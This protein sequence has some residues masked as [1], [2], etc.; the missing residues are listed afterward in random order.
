LIHPAIWRRRRHATIAATR[1][2]SK[3]QALA[4]MPG[5]MAGSIP[6]ISP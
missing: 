1:N 6:S 2:E 3:T 5:M 4:T